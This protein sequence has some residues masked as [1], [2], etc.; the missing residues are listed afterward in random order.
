[1]EQ[2]PGGLR[3]GR[4]K[5]AVHPHD[6]VGDFSFLA[7][8]LNSAQLVLGAFYVLRGELTFYALDE[9][10]VVK[11][12]PAPRFANESGEEAEARR[13]G[14]DALGGCGAL[15]GGGPEIRN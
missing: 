6:E 11:A 13:S 12:G 10:A 15:D 8:P 7:C 4:L 1:M 5:E 3:F 9:D 2:K 14:E